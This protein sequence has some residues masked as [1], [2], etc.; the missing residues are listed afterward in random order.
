MPRGRKPTLTPAVADKIVEC[1][2][3]GNF[4]AVAAQLVG[5]DPSTLSHWL[6][7]GE[8]RPDSI[9]GQFRQRVLRA[10]AEIES[11]VQAIMVEAAR[12]DAKYALAYAG[13]RWAAR[14]GRHDNVT[15]STPE[16]ER[17]SEASARERLV[18]RLGALLIA[19]RPEGAAATAPADPVAEIVA[20][21]EGTGDPQ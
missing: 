20:E 10:E 9:Y 11:E 13:R 5:V 15:V 17:S 14:W 2:R 7:K 12:M 21:V 18:E 3:G 19:S 1:V 8:R 6:A 4:F 16:D